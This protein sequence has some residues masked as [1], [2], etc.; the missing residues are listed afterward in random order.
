MRIDG[1][2]R[3]ARARVEPK[4]DADRGETECIAMALVETRRPLQ[5]GGDRVRA[6]RRAPRRSSPLMK[7]RSTPRSELPQHLAAFAPTA[8]SPIRVR[9]VTDTSMMLDS[10]A[11]DEGHY[12]GGEQG[13]TVVVN[14]HGL[15]D[16]P[17]VAEVQAVVGA[18]PMMS[19][20]AIACDVL[21]A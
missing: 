10:D 1:F 12:D 2:S 13:L 5:A 16:F 11:A 21:S 15:G 19:L 4:R 14:L 7:L 20:R 6:D 17:W 18:W 8:R 9:S 3:A